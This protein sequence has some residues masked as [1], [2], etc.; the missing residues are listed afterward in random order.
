LVILRKV[1][2]GRNARSEPLFVAGMARLVTKT[3][4]WRQIFLITLLC[5]S[6]NIGGVSS[7]NPGAF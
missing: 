2:Q 7:S 5:H 6:S 1:T 4:M 3:H